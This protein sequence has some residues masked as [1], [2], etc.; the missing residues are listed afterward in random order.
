MYFESVENQ[1]VN[2]HAFW[3]YSCW[4]AQAW[5]FSTCGQSYASDN[6]G[7]KRCCV[8]G[9]SC[10]FATNILYFMGHVVSHR[11]DWMITWNFLLTHSLIFYIYT[12]RK[13]TANVCIICNK[14]FRG[15][16]YNNKCRYSCDYFHSQHI[17]LL[18][19]QH[20][21]PPP[22]PPRSSL[23]FLFITAWIKMLLP[24]LSGGLLC[25]LSLVFECE[26]NKPLLAAV[27]ASRLI[28]KRGWNFSK[29]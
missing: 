12:I 6:A 1:G 11:Y 8:Q 16:I 25:F 2:L 29:D 20:S 26:K 3:R 28:H 19:N 9:F 23:P 17:K 7:H 24:V 4:R 18:V 27:F 5:S 14:L 21:L 22:F 13:I 15:W 10:S